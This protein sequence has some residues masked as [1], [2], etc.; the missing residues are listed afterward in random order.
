MSEITY[1]P[2]GTQIIVVEGAKA[3]EEGNLTEG[4]RTDTAYFMGYEDVTGTFF[5][6]HVPANEVSV[7]SDIDEELQRGALKQEVLNTLPNKKVSLNQFNNLSIGGQIVSA[8]S[9]SE[10]KSDLVNIS[11]VQSFIEDM[12]IIADELYWWKDS[13]YLNIVQENFAETG[14][15]E[16]NPAQM[17]EFLTKYN[18]SKDE[19]NGAIERATNPIGYKD[20]VGQYYAT[21]KAQAVELGGEVTD[22][23][24][25][26]LAEKWASGKFTATKVT[27]QLSAAL[28]PYSPFKIDKDI[29]DAFTD[30]TQISTGET[31]VQSLL[32]TY[33]PQHM[34]NQI[35][36]AEIAG[37][38][39][40]IGGYE[41][42][43]I[44]E[45]KDMRLVQYGMYDR[46]VKW[47]NILNTYKSQ[48]ADIWGITPADDDVAILDAIKLNNQTQ[49]RSDLK[50]IGLERGYQKTVNDFSSGLSD[51]FGTGIARSAGYL[52]G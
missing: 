6:W 24:A 17:A 9:Y 47:Q 21:I 34:H 12:S 31:K 2:K 8:G 15:Y 14:S 1:G 42:K 52:E 10:L 38:I 44:E 20:K 49:S 4:G 5:L 45:L 29:A 46:D 32:N 19:Y 7:V 28:D 27:Q 35:D 39:R 43:F 36:I 22:K 26:L 25:K 41:D 11:P 40:N 3:D 30:T 23:G 50:R 37:K 16:L 51:A 48:A 13:D 18:L 33:L